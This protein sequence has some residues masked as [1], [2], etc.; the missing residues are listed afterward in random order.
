MDLELQNDSSAWKTFET[1]ITK[2]QMPEVSPYT[3]SMTDPKYEAALRAVD[4]LRSG[5][6]VAYFEMGRVRSFASVNHWKAVFYHW[7]VFRLEE[8]GLRPD[9]RAGFNELFRRHHRF[10]EHAMSWR[11]S[12]FDVFRDALIEAGC[13]M[14]VLADFNLMFHMTW[15]DGHTASRVV[16]LGR[17]DVIEAI[18]A[19]RQD[20][21]LLFAALFSRE[22]CAYYGENSDRMQRQICD[23]LSVEWRTNPRVLDMFMHH[24]LWITTQTFT[25]DLTRE[26]LQGFNLPP[27]TF[28]FITESNMAFHAL[29]LVDPRQVIAKFQLTDEQFKEQL[30]DPGESSLLLARALSVALRW[31][32]QPTRVDMIIE[33]V[34]R[35]A[36]LH[37]N[38]TLF[39]DLLQLPSSN[40]VGDLS[41]AG[42][43]ARLK[44][45]FVDRL[46]A[47]TKDSQRFQGIPVYPL[48]ALKDAANPLILFDRLLDAALRSSFDLEAVMTFILKVIPFFHN[49]AV[50]HRN[51]T[52]RFL[53]AGKSAA[54]FDKLHPAVMALWQATKTI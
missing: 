47:S 41:P 28:D 16:I 31:P 10:M 36:Q 2:S 24:S 12:T 15:A 35:C 14:T 1:L 50:L 49:P 32:I 52:M 7:F 37:P 27:E 11:A 54:F 53:R 17:V 13:S 51:I 21:V 38:P 3:V 40:N 5:A 33:R 20:G 25:G 48:R 4:G 22:F 44:M 42:F 8:A 46:L 26:Y 30:S 34:K 19:S 9:D 43:F 23:V 18:L 39:E 6:I 45:P 29:T